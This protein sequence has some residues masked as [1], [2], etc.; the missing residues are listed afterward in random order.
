MVTPNICS[1]RFVDTET[2]HVLGLLVA[3]LDN[4]HKGSLTQ[5]DASLFMRSLHKLQP[6]QASVVAVAM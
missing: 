3:E 2:L 5:S 6:M 4:M 1:D